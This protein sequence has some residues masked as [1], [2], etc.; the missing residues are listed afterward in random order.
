LQAEEIHN[1]TEYEL[2]QELAAA[3]GRLQ[4]I[5]HAFLELNAQ[6]RETLVCGWVAFYV[7]AKF[8]PF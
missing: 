4:D 1:A 6:H 7:S 5:E 8:L 2:R 3:A